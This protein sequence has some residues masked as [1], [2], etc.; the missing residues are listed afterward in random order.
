MKEE[1]VVYCNGL[2][3]CSVCTNIKDPRM[4]EFKTNIQNPTG[5][6]S[7]GWKICKDPYFHTGQANPC[8][9]ERNP[10]THKHYLM[11]C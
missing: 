1:L 3:R 9:C 7:G 6:D 11:V 2:A 5:L 8:P 4:I 10:K